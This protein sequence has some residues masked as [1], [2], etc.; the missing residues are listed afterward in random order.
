MMNASLTVA[1]VV[2]VLLIVPTLMLW[3]RVLMARRRARRPQ[4]E[5][6]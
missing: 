5:E 3:T 2:A 6:T 1:S 4:E